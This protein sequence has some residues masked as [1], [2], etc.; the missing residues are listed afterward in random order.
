MSKENRPIPS[1]ANIF[2]VS[3]DSLPPK[4]TLFMSGFATGVA[5]LLAMLL[6]FAGWHVFSGP[7]F[8]VISVH[9]GMLLGTVAVM[10]RLQYRKVVT[11]ARA[12][13]WGLDYGVG[14]VGAPLGLAGVGLFFAGYEAYFPF[15]LFS[16]VIA[17][18]AGVAALAWMLLRYTMPRIVLQDGSRCPVCAYCLIGVTSMRCPECGRPFT[19]DELATTEAE[20][21][22]R[23]AP[24]NS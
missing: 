7:P 17:L 22:A 13:N 2:V 12:A 24:L 8:L 15:M 23:G 9:L 11:S 19:Y 1:I 5:V 16:L 3:L 6:M 21:V 20:F 18:L 4:T 10:L 14:V